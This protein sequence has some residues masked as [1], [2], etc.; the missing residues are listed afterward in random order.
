M[1]TRGYQI[2]HKYNNVDAMKSFQRPTSSTINKRKKP[3]IFTII[4]N[5]SVFL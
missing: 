5:M 3:M 2:T 4:D 1:N